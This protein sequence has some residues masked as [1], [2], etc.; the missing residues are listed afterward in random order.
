MAWNH[1]CHCNANKG[2]NG[3]FPD[4]SKT[5]HCEFW[6]L[7]TWLG[8]CDFPARH[9]AGCLFALKLNRLSDT[10]PFSIRRR[11]VRDELERQRGRVFVLPFRGLEG[12]ILVTVAWLRGTGTPVSDNLRQLPQ[13]V[14]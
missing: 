9:F 12:D 14:Q 5:E 1:F 13:Y 4:T 3:T 2:C 8:D 6:D 11:R 10:L 7:D